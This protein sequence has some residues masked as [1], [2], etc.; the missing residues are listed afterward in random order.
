MNPAQGPDHRGD[1]DRLPD[2][3]PRPRLP[4][5][6]HRHLPGGLP[7]QAP[8]AARSRWTARSSAPADRPGLPRPAALLP[9]P[10]LGDRIQRQRHLL[11]QPRPEQQGTVA[12]SSKPTA[13]PPRR[14]AYL[15]ART[16]LRPF[17]PDRRPT[18]AVDAVT[19]SASGVDPH[20]S[21]ANARIQAHRVAAVRSLPLARARRPD[22]RRTPTVASSAFSASPASTC[23]S[24][25][26]LST[27]KLRTDDR[28]DPPQPATLAVRP[29]DRPRRAL[30]SVRKLDPRHQV[31]NPVMFVV[32]I[33]AVITTVAWLIQVFGGAAAR[34]RPRA[35]LVHL[36][37]SPSGSG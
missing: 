1:R 2:G 32:E 18:V 24:S 29:R 14:E 5:G 3:L 7:R 36:Q 11:Q 17:G 9:G 33:G 4:A 37:R 13:R 6:D 15:T 23:S 19:Q 35:R 21:E 16:P 20:I 12:K 10:P 34:R 30:D 27:G 8:T 22:R 31:R 28:R 26:S 25:T